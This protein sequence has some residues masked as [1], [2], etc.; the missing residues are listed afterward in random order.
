M[1]CATYV[2]KSMTVALEHA[3]EDP[4]GN[5]WVFVCDALIGKYCQGTRGHVEPP[6][7]QERTLL[8]YDSTV[9]VEDNP[10]KYALFSDYQILVRYLIKFEK[11]ASL[12]PGIFKLLS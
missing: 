12:Q 3:P 6:I 11:K 1:G 7:R 9:D 8:R 4:A 5:R 2:S 10:T